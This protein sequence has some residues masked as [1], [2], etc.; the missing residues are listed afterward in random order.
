L[1]FR[2]F[3]WL[4][5]AILVT[6]LVL[7]WPLWFRWLGSYLVSA[8]SPCH[9]DLI[10]VLGGDYRGNRILKA[11]ELIRQG[12]APR[13]LV[14]GPGGFYGLYESDMAIPFAVRHGYPAEWFTGFP[15]EGQSTREEAAAIL[16]ELRRRG[17]RRFVLVTSDYHTRRAGRMF[18]SQDP[19][20]DFCVVAARDADFRQ[21]NWWHNREGQKQFA[22]EWL[23]TVATWVGL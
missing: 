2:R 16:P 17:V 5:P 7:A 22:L 8:G 14:S 3:R 11:G 6:A 18:R 13:A 21:N 15:H 23:K 1:A 12:Y 4:I 9:G 20:A 10:V 19:K